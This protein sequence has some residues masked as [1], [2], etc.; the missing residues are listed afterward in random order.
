MNKR[1]ATA[2]APR[3]PATGKTV[4]AAA[5]ARAPDDQL[6]LYRR[7]FAVSA[8]AIAVISPNGRYMQQNDAHREMT[9]YQDDELRTRTPAVHL[10]EET[11]ARIGAELE[12]KG[13]Y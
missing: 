8:D 3:K 10:G 2:S 1:S 12:A 11:F 6:E 9:G 7:I 13:S 5:P 4:A